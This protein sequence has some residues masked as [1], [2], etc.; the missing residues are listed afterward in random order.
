M[1]L[2]DVIET[3][4]KLGWKMDVLWMVDMLTNHDHHTPL[5]TGWNSRLIPRD[6]DIQKI[7]Q[8]PQLNQSPTS[9]T[10]AI[11]AMRRSLAIAAECGRNCISVT[12]DLAIAKVAMQI[13]YKERPAFCLCCTRSISHR[14]GTF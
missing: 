6:E 7:W 3:K 10:V 1:T 13:Q 8:L 2:T 11:E 5:W 9:N 4:K 12:Y 14:N